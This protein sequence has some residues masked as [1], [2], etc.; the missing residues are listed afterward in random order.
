MNDSQ[1][2][3][4]KKKTKLIIDQ[5]FDNVEIQARKPCQPNQEYIEVLALVIT[6]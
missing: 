3:K 2:N 1:T 5:N 4:G 6:Q